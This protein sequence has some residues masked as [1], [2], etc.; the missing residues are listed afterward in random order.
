M[1]DRLRNFLEFNG[2]NVISRMADRFGVRASRL[3]LLFIYL[4]FVTLGVTFAFYLIMAFFLWVKD[5]VVIRR[6]SVFD[7]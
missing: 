3:R 6:K 7:L 5:G 2:F 4:S 1:F